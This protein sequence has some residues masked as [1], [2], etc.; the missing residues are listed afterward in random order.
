M[1]FLS[2]AHIWITISASVSVAFQQG[3]RE[4]FCITH[5]IK[6]NLNPRTQRGVGLCLILQFEVI[7]TVKTNLY[8]IMSERTCTSYILL[9]CTGNDSHWMT[10]EV[11]SSSPL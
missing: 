4:A 1:Y 8:Y 11:D 2:S 9:I 7:Y 6:V 3:S 10:D 5:I